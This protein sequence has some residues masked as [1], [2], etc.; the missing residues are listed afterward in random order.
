MRRRSFIPAARFGFLTRHYDRICR[1]L[2]LGVALRRV[3]VA[4]LDGLAP[5]RILEVGC[6]TGEL[7]RA[8]A[9][10]FPAAEVTGLD[11]D[12]RA[13]AIAEEKL[14]A[15][16]LPAHFVPGR[17]ERL[18][19]SEG[20]FDLVISSLMLHHLDTAA[21]QS[22]LREWRRV[23]VP[24]GALRLVDFG[25]PRSRLL[26]ALLWPLRFGLFEE[27][28]DNFRGRIPEMLSQAGFE[29]QEAGRYGWVV[30]AYRA[31]PSRAAQGQEGGGGRRASPADVSAAAPWARRS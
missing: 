15:E 12:A 4:L 7:L 2:G 25:A 26:R 1:A 3:Q 17:A 10:R 5:R 16:A 19:F 18:P 11:P 20:S 8:V 29:I 31:R 28:G 9:R 21:K 13:L 23:L 6:G 27:E 30:V 22:A 24:G 14:R